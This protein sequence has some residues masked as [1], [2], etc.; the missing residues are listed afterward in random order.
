MFDKHFIAHYDYGLLYAHIN[1]A[2]YTKLGKLFSWITAAIQIAGIALIL[3]NK[4]GVNFSQIEPY[5]VS[6]TG[7]FLVIGSTAIFAIMAPFFTHF[8]RNEKPKRPKVYHFFKGNK[9]VLNPIT[10]LGLFISVF[11]ILVFSI[12]I[13]GTF[14][15]AFV[16]RDVKGALL[17]V[18]IIACCVAFYIY[19]SRTLTEAS[20]HDQD[21]N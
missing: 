11:F 15:E 18:L 8:I 20:E 16:D 1:F 9:G 4:Y 10:P 13:I 2:P 17:G 3:S 12:T 14:L 7:W 5:N 21:K 19:A 6:K